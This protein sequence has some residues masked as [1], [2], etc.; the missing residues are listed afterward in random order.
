MI[1][2]YC[3]KFETLSNLEGQVLVLISPRNRVAQLYVQV[4]GSHFVASIDS[5]GYG[6]GI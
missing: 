6:G 3:F 5:Q 1:I 4:L 2:F